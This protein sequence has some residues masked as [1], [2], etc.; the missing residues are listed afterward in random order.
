MHNQTTQ[1]DDIAQASINN[2]TKWRRRGFQ[3]EPS[4]KIGNPSNGQE[5]AEGS[6]S[7]LGVGL[8]SRPQLREFQ[9]LTVEVDSILISHP[10]DPGATLNNSTTQHICVHNQTTQADDI[11]QA[12][13][14]YATK[15][16][17]RGFQVEP[18]Y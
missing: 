15:W 3:V 17:R 4:Y 10:H 16:R 7:T 18:S 12:S 14:N 6:K 1:A 5:T 13:I 8:I 9:N 2:A 11:A